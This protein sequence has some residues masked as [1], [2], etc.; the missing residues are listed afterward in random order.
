MISLANVL[1]AILIAFGWGQALATGEERAVEE[2]LQAYEQAWSRHDGPAVASFYHEPAVRVTKGGPVVRA[3]RGEQ[4]VFFSSFLRGLVQR[5]YSRS[6]WEE[7]EVRLLDPETAIASGVTVRYRTDG[8]VVERLAVTYGLWR[9]SQGWKIFWSATHPP[10][11]ML[12]F[13]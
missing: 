4:E 8:T 9:T 7:L 2:V 13:R 3:S 11:T 6:A 10:D 1:V 5:G 12:K